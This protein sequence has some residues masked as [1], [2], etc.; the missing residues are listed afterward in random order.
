MRGYIVGCVFAA[1]GASLLALVL[2]LPGPAVAENPRIVLIRHATADQGTDARHVR[3]DDCTTQRNLSSEGR[4]E[5][6]QMGVKFRDHGFLVTRV[7]VSP[8]CRTM[9]TARL[10]KL[11]R[12]EASPAFR[13]VR[14][15]QDALAVARLGAAR[16]I[17]DSWRGAGI[18]VIVTHASTIKAL[19]GLEPQDGKFIVYVN[20]R[21]DAAGATSNLFQM[22]F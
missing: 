12:I 17:L 2:I 11:S 10:M 18:L 16:T 22:T 5:A 8:F 4:L 6:Q 19:T 20:R 7:L 9:E 15:D 21:A 1:I 3:F 13:N 14:S